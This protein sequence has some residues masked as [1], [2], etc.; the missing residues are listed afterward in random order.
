MAF[1]FGGHGGGHGGGPGGGPG[2]GGHGPGFGGPGFGHGP[3][4][5][6]HGFGGYGFGPGHFGGF[7]PG[8]G[9][10]GGFFGFGPGFAHFGPSGGRSAGAKKNGAAAEAPF[11]EAFPDNLCASEP[12]ETAKERVDLFIINSHGIKRALRWLIGFA[13]VAAVLVTLTTALSGG[14]HWAWLFMVSPMV[15]LSPLCYS[16][17]NLVS[18]FYGRWL[19]NC[20]SMVACVPNLVAAIITIFAPGSPRVFFAGAVGFLLGSFVANGMFQLAGQ[21]QAI[22]GFDNDNKSYRARTYGSALAG[23]AVELICFL[24]LAFAGRIDGFGMIWL[25]ACVFGLAFAVEFALTPV[26]CFLRDRIGYQLHAS[27]DYI[28]DE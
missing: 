5:F 26:T 4:G 9:M 11:G 2:T 13:V 1:G 20:L 22:R 23:R 18:E 17:R 25:G 7:G 27:N 15:I 8:F 14:Y 24:P 19:A 28:V 12:S 6:G 10:F 16:L 3:G 21:S